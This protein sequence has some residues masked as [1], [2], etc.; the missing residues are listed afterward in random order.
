[1]RITVH[2]RPDE[3]VTADLRAL[4]ARVESTHGEMLLDDQKYAQLDDGGGWS[5]V[6]AHDGDRLLG[7]GHLRWATPG[8]H[9]RASVEVAVDPTTEP[10]DE[11]R[12]RLIQ[13]ATGAVAEAGGGWLHVWERDASDPGDTAPARSGMAVQRRLARMEAPLAEAPRPPALPPGVTIRGYRPG[14][15]DAALLAV[16]NA[17][18]AGH[19]EQGGWTVDDL[20][21]RRGRGWFD[22]GDVLIA[23][24][25]DDLAGFHWTRLHAGTPPAGEVYVLAVA[26]AAQGLGLGRVLLLAGLDHLHRR[27]ARVALLYV[28]LAET[29][30]VRLYESA[31]F[32]VV[33]LDV[34]YE[35]HVDPA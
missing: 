15:D 7:Y 16:N 14:E 3:H 13:A 17:A 32:A 22:P 24:R 11:L 33:R 9:P 20:A 12:R 27:G 19:P 23:W 35:Q 1:M 4:L 10:A 28:D 30:A 26:P 21:A 2:D 5:A 34:C 31:G 29:G 25:G 6:L 8:G 18:F